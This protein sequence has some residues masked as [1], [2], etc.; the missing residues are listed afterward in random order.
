[1]LAAINR[2]FGEESIIRGF[3]LHGNGRSRFT[4]IAGSFLF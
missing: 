4:L 3:P 2:F 1:M